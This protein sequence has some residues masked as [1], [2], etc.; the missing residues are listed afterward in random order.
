MENT[1]E[2]LDDVLSKNKKEDLEVNI[3]IININLFLERKY[4]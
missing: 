3:N 2:G 4:S 1:L